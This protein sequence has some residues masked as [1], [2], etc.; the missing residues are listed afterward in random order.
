MDMISTPMKIVELKRGPH[1]GQSESGRTHPQ[2]A[3]QPGA[4]H[5]PGG[6]R[7]MAGLLDGLID[8]GGRTR[9]RYV[10]R[11]CSSAHARSRSAYPA[12]RHRLR[13]HHRSGERAWFPGDEEV[14]RRYR[15]WNR[16][17]AA[18][19]V[20]RAQR[21]G[22]EVGGHISTYASSATLYEVG[23]NH[24]F[25]GRTIPAAATTSSTRATPPR[26]VR[27]RLPRRP[28]ERR[29]ARRIP[30]AAVALH[31]RQAPGTA[32]LPAPAPAARLLGAPHGVDGPRP[33]ERDRAGT[34]RQVPV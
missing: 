21:P 1:R 34:V 25:R 24:F 20:H 31:R 2:R 27:P 17:N 32:V 11:A 5:R 3:A 9:A 13:Q 8:E 16:W 10:M 23:L 7:R 26:H 29:T 28:D 15:R 22:V 19:L 4:R 33:D 30:P 12:S 6:D 18:M 14:E